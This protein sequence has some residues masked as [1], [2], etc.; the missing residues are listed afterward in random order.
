[1]LVRNAILENDYSEDAL[2]E[3]QDC[4]ACGSDGAAICAFLV[5]GCT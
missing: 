2:C 4:G 5:L 1:M 3:D